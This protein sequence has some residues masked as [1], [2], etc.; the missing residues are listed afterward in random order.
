MVLITNKKAQQVC[1]ARCH[2]GCVCTQNQPR[3][4]GSVVGEAGCTSAEV[5]TCTSSLPWPYSSLWLPCQELK[6]LCTLL[7]LFRCDVILRREAA[8][9]ASL[10]AQRFSSADVES[11]A[12][13]PAGAGLMLHLASCCPTQSFTRSQICSILLATGTGTVST[14]ADPHC[15]RKD[16][17]SVSHLEHT[18]PRFPADSPRAVH[19]NDTSATLGHRSAIMRLKCATICARVGN[20]HVPDNRNSQH[21]ASSLF[22]AQGSLQLWPNAQSCNTQDA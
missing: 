6:S 4:P 20:K 16:H 19:G 15:F 11:S 12:Q 13:E 14:P 1:A 5:Q 17:T 7:L 8:G 22:K 18:V 21:S 2:K 10:Q 3:G 9:L